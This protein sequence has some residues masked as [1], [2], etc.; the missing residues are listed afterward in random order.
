[1][2]AHFKALPTCQYGVPTHYTPS[3]V[4]S[5][6]EPA[7]SEVW[8]RADKLDLMYVCTVHAEKIEESEDEEDDGQGTD[9]KD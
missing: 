5:C 6:G 8:W 3:G 1:M 9:T 2:Y 7:A 4:E